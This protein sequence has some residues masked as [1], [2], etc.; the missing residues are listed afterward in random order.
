[1]ATILVS[2]VGGP[3]G[4]NVAK[5]LLA[6]GFG[7]V[8]TDMRDMEFPGIV[9][10]RVPPAADADYL[11]ATRE[12]ATREKTVLFIPTISDELTIVAA[13]WS[14]IPAVISPSGAAETA[15]DKYRTAVALAAAGV[16]VPR[17][18]LPSQM[19]SPE[20]LA[21]RIGWPCISKPR[22]GRGGRGVLIRETVDWPEVAVLDDGYILQEFA[23]G[24]DYAP[25]VFIA[26]DGNDLVVVLEKTELKEGRVGNASSVRRVDDAEVGR[27][28]IA[29]ARAAGLV[30]PQD[31]D[32][33]K[34][35][36]GQ[37]VVLEIN[38]R[39]GANIRSTP[40]VFEALLAQMESDAWKY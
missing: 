9:F 29:A 26:Q 28:A 17:F 37:P 13:G 10:F 20:E 35:S 33:R 2:G 18:A 22:V 38:A 21:E 23:S 27:V 19:H 40:E 32:I 1:M 5:L 14:G 3:A 11:N 24:I 31:V 16:P 34:R 8:G 7:V 30:G 39:F 12:I 4:S 36:D 6:R 15:N 25:N